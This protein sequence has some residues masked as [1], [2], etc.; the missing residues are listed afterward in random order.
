MTR[1]SPLTVTQESP[2]S[3]TRVTPPVTPESPTSDTGVTH[4]SFKE[5]FEGNSFHEGERRFATLPFKS[6]FM[7]RALEPRQRVGRGSPVRQLAHE[8][9]EILGTSGRAPTVPNC[10]STCP[11]F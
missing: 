4:N 1:V 8:K 9:E 11:F 3:A 2:T 6:V 7:N 5:L 10:L